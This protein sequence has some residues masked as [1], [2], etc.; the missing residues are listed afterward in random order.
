MTAT[1][2]RCYGTSGTL[3]GMTD[4]TP[5]D[6]S[7]LARAYGQMWDVLRSDTDHVLVDLYRCDRDLVER[8]AAEW[9]NAHP[10]YIE[11]PPPAAAARP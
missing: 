11:N 6:L 5:D 7:P 4:P 1:A 8:A 3:P 9:F 10:D 2:S